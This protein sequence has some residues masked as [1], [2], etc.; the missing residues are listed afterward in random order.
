MKAPDEIAFSMHGLK[1]CVAKANIDC[2]Q[3][4][5]KASVLT[6][7]LADNIQLVGVFKLSGKQGK[8]GGKAWFKAAKYA[9]FGWE[10]TADFAAD[11]DHKFL[12]SLDF[13][14]GAFNF[15]P[16][17]SFYIKTEDVGALGLKIYFDHVI[18]F[19]GEYRFG[20]GGIGND[21]IA[22]LTLAVHKEIFKKIVES[23]G[24]DPK[25]TAPPKTK[26]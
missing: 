26:S 10:T 15:L 22:Y 25:E 9:W 1:N 23:F 12:I 18:G 19:G 17:G 24:A 16:Y 8:L 4:K 21:I 7:S 14:Q 2:H 13:T 3:L 6:G 5:L 11:I 20:K